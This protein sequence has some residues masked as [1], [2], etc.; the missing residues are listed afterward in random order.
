MGKVQCRG[1]LIDY[2]FSSKRV[3]WWNLLFVK[4]ILCVAG[5][6]KRFDKVNGSRNFAIHREIGFLTQGTSPISSF[7]TEVKLL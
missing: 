5:S 4:C 2:E 1:D 6:Q 3:I 7:F